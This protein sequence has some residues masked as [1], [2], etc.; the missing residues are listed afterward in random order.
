MQSPGAAVHC[1]VK[2]ASLPKPASE[3]NPAA[4]QACGSFHECRISCKTAVVTVTTPQVAWGPHC[5]RPL[6]AAVHCCR[7][8]PPL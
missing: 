7:S 8:L 2:R 3:L 6:W 4:L 5:C 1:W